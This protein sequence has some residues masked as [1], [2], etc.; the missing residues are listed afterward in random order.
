MTQREHAST[1]IRILREA[2]VRERIPVHPVTRYRWEKAGRFPR[3]VRLGPNSVGW[4]EHEIDAWLASRAANAP[5]A[6]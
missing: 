6:W 3:R 2:A 5:E 4:Y 1:H